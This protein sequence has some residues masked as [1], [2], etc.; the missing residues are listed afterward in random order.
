MNQPLTRCPG[1]VSR[2]SFLRI[3]ALAPLGL[4]LPALLAAAPPQ[5]PARAKSV[6]L[7]FLGGGI[8]HH[9]S[10]DMKPD[11]VEQIR[12]KYKSIPT[13][14]PTRQPRNAYHSTSGRSATEKPSR[15]L[16]NV[17]TWSEPEHAGLER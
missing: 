8:S 1:P 16:S 13:S 17:S 12:G 14:V 5:R 11:A 10:F 7:V 6:I 3:G 15:R 4:S 9:D 2:R